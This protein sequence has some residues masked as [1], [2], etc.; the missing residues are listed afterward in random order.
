MMTKY[1]GN[2]CPQCKRFFPD[3]PVRLVTEAYIDGRFIRMCPLC[4]ADH[5]YQAHGIH[6]NPTGEMASLM[7]ELAQLWVTSP[8]KYRR[9][10]LKR[11]RG[12]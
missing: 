5:Y 10:Y 11:K 7:L 8:G 9:Q 12:T 4:Y 6:W 2:K 3:T 1:S